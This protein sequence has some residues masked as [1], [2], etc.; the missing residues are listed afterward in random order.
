MLVCVNDAISPNEYD[1]TWPQDIDIIICTPDQ[2]Y[3]ISDVSELSQGPS[4][5]DNTN[6]STE[7]YGLIY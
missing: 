7:E 1:T 4:H 2:S 3:S 6:S 5:P